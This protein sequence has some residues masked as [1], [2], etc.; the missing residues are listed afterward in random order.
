MFTLKCGPGTSVGI[1]TGYGMDDFGIESRWVTKFS[2]PVQIIPG[3][4]P[5]SCRMGTGSFPG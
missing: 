4:H 2:V 5:A 1:V 3:T